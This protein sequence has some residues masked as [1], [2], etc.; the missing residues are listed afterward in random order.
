MKTLAFILALIAAQASA[1][2]YYV[3]QGVKYHIGD[4]HFNSST[5]KDFVGAYPVVGQE[6]IQ[7]F[8]VDRPDKVKVR[9][10]KVWGVDD[11]EYCRDLVWIDD[12]LMGRLYA[13]DKEGGFETLE[14]LAKQVVPGKI[15]YLKVESAGLQAD[16][17]IIQNVIVETDKAELTLME[18][19][20]VIKNPGE[21]MPVIYP[22]APQRNP[23]SPCDN[24]PVNHNWMLGWKNAAAVAVSF[25]AEGKFKASPPVVSLAKGQAVDIDVSISGIVGKDAVSQPFECLVGAAP[26]DGWALLYSAKRELIEH[27]NLILGGDYTAEAFKIG[28]WRPGSS[29]RLRVERCRDGNLRLL[30]NGTEASKT[31]KSESESCL[32]S[33]RAQGLNMRLLSATAPEAEA[34]Q[35]LPEAPNSEVVK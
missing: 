32:I 26:Y 19:G 22:P 24:L 2:V 14:P 8:K 31:L 4:A 10:E 29:N 27:G 3:N 21:P 20:P 5:D 34:I 11:C 28:S 7:A 6:W 35:G 15:Y 25:S 33:F 1:K 16:D 18:P 9:I 17:F 13:H 23:S 12:S 30:I